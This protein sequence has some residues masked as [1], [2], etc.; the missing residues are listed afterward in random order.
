LGMLGGQFPAKTKTLNAISNTKI[1]G[2]T[3]FI[4]L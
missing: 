2:I 4:L 1:I 3:F